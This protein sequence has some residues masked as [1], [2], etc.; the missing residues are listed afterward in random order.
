MARWQV[1]WPPNDVRE[2][3]AAFLALVFTIA[4]E[5]WVSREWVH[6]EQQ[7]AFPAGQVAAAGN[8]APETLSN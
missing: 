4:S 7:A 5:K 8:I 6:L 3:A 1:A 2:V